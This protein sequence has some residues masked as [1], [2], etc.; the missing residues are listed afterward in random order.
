MLIDRLFYMENCDAEQKLERWK[1]TGSLGLG[2]KRIGCGINALTFLNYLTRPIGELII[3]DLKRQVECGINYGTSSQEIIN[4]I[5]RSSGISITRIKQKKYPITNVNEVQT[6]INVI[7]DILPFNCCTIVKLLRYPDNPPR[8]ELLDPRCPNAGPGHTVIFSNINGKLTIVDPQLVKIYPNINAEDTFNKSWNNQCY[9]EANVMFLTME[10]NIPKPLSSASMPAN[11]PPLPYYGEHIVGSL[12]YMYL[13]EKYKKGCIV[14]DDKIYLDLGTESQFKTNPNLMMDRIKVIS[15]KFKKCYDKGL[16]MITIPLRF[17]LPP[18]DSYHINF[19]LFK[20]STYTFERFEPHGSI[21]KA[22]FVDDI[23]QIFVNEINN[24]ISTKPREIVYIPIEI[25]CPLIG[26]QVIEE[27]YENKTRPK[28][29]EEWLGYCMIWSMLFTEMVFNNPQLNTKELTNIMLNIRSKNT[30]FIDIARGYVSYVYSVM[31]RVFNRY[32]IPISNELIGSSIN[33]QEYI[34]Y[35]LIKS[36]QLTGTMDQ[37]MIEAHNI[38]I[39]TIQQYFNIRFNLNYEHATLDILLQQD[40]NAY[41]VASNQIDKNNIFLSMKIIEMMKSQP[42]PMIIE[43]ILPSPMDIEETQPSPMEIEP[44]KPQPA[45]NMSD[46]VSQFS[47]FQFGGKK[48]RIKH[49][50]SKQTKRQQKKKNKQTNKRRHKNKQTKRQQK[51][52]KSKRTI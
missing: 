37:N 5:S 26:V 28:Q 22:E 15:Q 4:F 16:D 6:F 44:P 42:V 33:F 29:P 10:F 52:I 51:R 49:K 39:M 47:S 1:E 45:S 41:Q 48:L 30:V 36:G 20:R 17:G 3:A 2:E 14:S 18:T 31:N 32:V 34:T 50:K 11:P 8:P 12:F 23:I 9:R 24:L 25:S 13:F 40:M 43:E 27:Q 21:S 38:A 35:S 19:L 46:I 7:L